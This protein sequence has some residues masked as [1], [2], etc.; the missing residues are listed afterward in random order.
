MNTGSSPVPVAILGTGSMGGAMAERLLALGWP[1]HVRDLVEERMQALAALG[2]TAHHSAADAAAAAQVVIV[3]VVDATQCR[4]VL[5]DEG[6]ARAQAL[7]GS[8]LLCPTLGPP[9]VEDIAAALQRQGLHALDA[10]ISG[11]P[12]RAREG[13][14]SMMVACSPSGWLRCHGLLAALSDRVFRIGERPGDGAR[15]KLVNN[16]AAA[17]NLAGA[18]E[19]LALAERLGLDAAVT[20][21][22]IEQS[23][24]QSWIG[25]DRMRRALA[26]DLAP[27]ARLA[28][29]EKDTRLALESADAAGFHGPLGERVR[30]L[31]AQVAE[32]GQRE[33]DDAVLL[34]WLRRQP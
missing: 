15:T 24:G 3:C 2:A 5:F 19:V 29:L 33:R 1:V 7:G 8:V 25:S 16:L 17:I 12:A 32:G 6:A 14:I 18:A 31:F 34:D 13:R 22:V 11:G 30:D 4:R 28:M 20:Q 9:E 10:P 21:Q 27:R 23:S 26:G